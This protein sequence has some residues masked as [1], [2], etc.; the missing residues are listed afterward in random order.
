VYP[1][2]PWVSPRTLRKTK[3]GGWKPSSTIG[4]AGRADRSGANYALFLT[5]L[6]SAL[7]LPDPDPDHN[8]E[9]DDYVFERVVILAGWPPRSRSCRHELPSRPTQSRERADLNLRDHR[10]IFRRRAPRVFE[11]DEGCQRLV[12][13]SEVGRSPQ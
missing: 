4:R 9:A 13:L 6:C 1:A 2:V 5:Q 8:P 12:A 11:G 3:A 7:G 10:L